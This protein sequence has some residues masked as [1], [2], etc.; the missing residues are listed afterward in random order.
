MDPIHFARGGSQ[1]QWSTPLFGICALVFIFLKIFTPPVEKT[2][3]CIMAPSFFSKLLISLAWVDTAPRPRRVLLI[4]A[5]Q[6]NQYSQIPRR[7][8]IG[9]CLNKQHAFY[10]SLPKI[11]SITWF[12]RYKT[13]VYFRPLFIYL[14]CHRNIFHFQAAKFKAIY[15]W[16]LFLTKL[17]KASCSL[18]FKVFSFVPVSDSSFNC[19]AFIRIESWKHKLYEGDNIKK[20]SYQHFGSLLSTTETSFFPGKT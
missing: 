3:I 14:L 16:F 5:S 11:Q 1:D 19:R 7:S 2:L 9:K 18:S 4:L 8:C 20:D 6:P 10:T 13:N 15:P 17:R 12:T